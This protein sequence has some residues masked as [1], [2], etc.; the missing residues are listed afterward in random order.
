M[1]WKSVRLGIKHS[2]CC[3]R[4]MH[5]VV[6]M[7]TNSHAAISAHERRQC[8]RY[9]MELLFYMRRDGVKLATIALWL[10]ARAKKR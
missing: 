9:E 2:N 6:K 3:F 7:A 4:V 10:S 5:D 1:V 8:G